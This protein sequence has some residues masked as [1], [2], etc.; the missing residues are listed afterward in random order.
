MD[1]WKHYV[2]HR[3]QHPY[4]EGVSFKMSKQNSYIENKTLHL[5]VTNC[6]RETFLEN[7]SYI[8]TDEVDG[9]LKCGTRDKKE[10]RYYRNNLLPPF[11][12]AMLQSKTK[13]RHVR[14]D[15]EAQ[16][17]HGDFL[18]SGMQLATENDAINIAIVRGNSELKDT[19]NNEV[20]GKSLF[21]GVLR[22]S[23]D[24]D[25]FEPHEADQFFRSDEHFGNR[26]HTYSAIWKSDS[27]T[28][29]L[30]GQT[31][32]IFDNKEIMEEI[33]LNGERHIQLFLTVGGELHFP[34]SRIVKGG[35]FVHSNA[36]ISSIIKSH[37][38]SSSWVQPKLSIRSIKVYST[39]KNE[40]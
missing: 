11:Q 8:G 26:Y 29:K 36:K 25:K 19:A 3:F 12:A 30:N 34:D 31:Y 16:V 13:F 21:A 17:A 1:N 4:R 7:C 23:P 22:K 33:S 38:N 37:V 2:I 18:F 27:I 39:D 28:F 10:E 40:I 15:I 9:N 20:G 32:A 24:K 6:T 35:N 5:K 14:I